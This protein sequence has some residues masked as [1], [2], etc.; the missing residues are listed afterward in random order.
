VIFVAVIL[1]LVGGWSL[2]GGCCGTGYLAMLATMPEQP[3]GKI[4]GAPPGGDPGEMQR[5]M[6]KEA[7]GYYPVIFTLSGIDI[8]FG[9]GQVIAG[10]GLLRLS[11]AARIM[12]IVLTLGKLFF[13]FAGH[14]YNVIFVTP[15]QAKFFEQNPLPPGAPFDLASFTRAATWL[16]LGIV[17]VIQLAL[18]MAIV[19]PLVMSNVRQAFADA[20]NP[21]SLED[22][23]RRRDTGYDDDYSGP[24]GRQSDTGIQE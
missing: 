2:L 19:I 10:I 7:P 8:L 21:P 16:V 1:F 5:F 22:G 17:V 23:P 18:V 9:L 20:A 14:A 4:K 11:S 6:A 24:T 15:A 12:T 13:S 3:G